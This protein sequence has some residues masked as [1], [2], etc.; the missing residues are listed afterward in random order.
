MVKLVYSYPTDNLMSTVE[1]VVLSTGVAESSRYDVDKV[2]DGDPACPLKIVGTSMDL[3]MTWASAVLPVFPALLHWNLTVAARLQG[4]DTDLNS[5]DIDVPFS[6][7]TMS[8]GKWFTSP[9]L[10]NTGLT[11]KK[12]W[13]IRVV[14]N[15]YPIIAG[16]LWMGS[17]YRQLSESDYLLDDI[18]FDRAGRAI[19]H[20][21]NHDVTL[22][23]S[24][25]SIRDVYAGSMI[26]SGSDLAAVLEWIEAARG[27]ARPFVIMLDSTVQNAQMVTFVGDNFPRK[28]LGNGYFKIPLPLQA[29]S[30][31]LQW[32]DPDV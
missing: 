23:Y 2:Y 14:S 3:D 7:P 1:S 28:P 11:A 13:R 10:N 21:T 8:I 25:A 6:I 30:R 20:P 29:V 15:A 27:Q 19:V 4:D 9:S 24:Q 12:K 18:V 5:P 16:E 17:A 22:R 26:V 31:G 32:V